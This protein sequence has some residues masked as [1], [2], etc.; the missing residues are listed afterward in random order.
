MDAQPE[1]H[2][3]HRRHRLLLQANVADGGL[4]DTVAAVAGAISATAA[5][6]ALCFSANQNAQSASA[7]SLSSAYKFSDEC[8]TL[9]KEYENAKNPADCEK[10]LQEI[11]GSFELFSAAVNDG[12]LTPRIREYIVE[13]MCDYLDGMVT[14]GCHGYVQPSTQKSHVC[15]ELKSL[16]IQHRDKFEDVAAVAAMLNIPKSSVV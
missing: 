15:K 3:H 8:R 16:V 14:A 9:W 1:F 13:T 4:A 2:R 10:A 11:L 7:L 5:F 12:S 6:T